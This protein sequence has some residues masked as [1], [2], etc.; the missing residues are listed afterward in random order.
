MGNH[1]KSDEKIHAAENR[2][3]EQAHVYE[4]LKSYSVVLFGTAEEGVGLRV[5]PMTIARV[6]EDCTV[7]FVTALDTVSARTAGQSSRDRL[8]AQASSRFLV[9]QGSHEVSTDRALLKDLWSAPM[10]AWF[11]GPDDPKACA[12]V[13]TPTEAELWDNTGIA[14]LRYLFQAA[15]AV[16]TGE[17]PPHTEDPKLHARIPITH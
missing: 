12:I 5:R 2:E 1:S 6:D 11:D 15:K 16:I 3:L 10:D 8:F 14:G 9:M 4:M 7:Y 13:Y 17:K